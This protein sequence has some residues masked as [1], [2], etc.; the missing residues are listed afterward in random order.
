MNRLS[1]IWSVASALVIAGAAPADA[2]EAQP[3]RLTL[4]TAANVSLRNEVQLAIDRGLGWLRTQQATNGSWSDTNHPALTALALTALLTEPSGKYRRQPPEFIR[5]GYA[6]LHANARADGGIYVEKLQNYNTSL[7][8]MALLAAPDPRHEELIRRA[9]AFIASQQNDFG[10]RGRADVP[11]DGGVGYGNSTPHADLSNTLVALEALR[12]SRR[13]EGDAA[14]ELNWA[15]AIAFIQRCQNLPSHNTEPW[16]SDDPANRGGFVYFPGK[17]MAGETNLAGG[18][19][20]L[21]SYGTMTYAGLLSYI[22]ADLK[23][24]DPRVTAAADWLRR[25]FTLAEN[26]GMGQEGLYYYYHLMAKTLSVL[27]IPELVLSD[28]RVVNWREA[29]AKRLFDLQAREGFWVNSNGR[30]L[31]KDPVLVTA[32]A[33]LALNRIAAGL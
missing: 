26:P 31:E 27:D 29:L 4:Q 16:A 5:R 25:H 1:I 14:K 28:Q 19:V 20:A 33:V 8:V 22:Y 24:D 15:A 2:A 32:Y 30:W 9:R 23:R 7:A 6:F 18:R 11:W 21:R 17:S 10:E 3:Q 13:G 12:L